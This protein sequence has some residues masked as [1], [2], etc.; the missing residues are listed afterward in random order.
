MIIMVMDCVFFK[1]PMLE[2]YTE[3]FTGKLYA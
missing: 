2:T 3:I 1:N